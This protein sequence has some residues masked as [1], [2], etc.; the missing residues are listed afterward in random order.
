M[1]QTFVRLIRLHDMLYSVTKNNVEVLIKH[2]SC[3][4]RVPSDSPSRGTL[5]EPRTQ[6]NPP[7]KNVKMSLSTFQGKESEKKKITYFQ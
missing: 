6:F 4:T 1:I 2:P 7:V 5:E 3:T